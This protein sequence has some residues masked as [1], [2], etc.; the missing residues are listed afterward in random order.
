M[1]ENKIELKSIS[2]LLGKHF[3]IP[4][5]QRGYRWEEQQIIDL[6]ND[7]LEFHKKVNSK[8]IGVGE[9]YCLQPLIVIQRIKMEVSRC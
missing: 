2:E 3:Y 7:I 9:F 4:S 8:K 5:Y 6:L 1:T